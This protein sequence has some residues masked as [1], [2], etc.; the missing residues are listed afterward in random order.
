MSL[1]TPSFN[2]STSGSESS[3]RIAVMGASAVGKSAIV[4]QFVLGKFPRGYAATIQER[5]IR[6]IDVNGSHV[7]LDIFDTPGAYCFANVRRLAIANAE[8]FVLVYSVGDESSFENMAKMRDLIVQ[9]KSD[10]VPILVVGN[11]SD[12]TT[13]DRFISKDKAY[14]MVTNGWNHRYMEASAKDNENILE[15]FQLIV[16]QTK[17]YF[18]EKSRRMTS[19]TAALKRLSC[20]LRRSMT[21]N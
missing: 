7:V 1:P 10:G 8:A 2:S 9:E 16:S 13:S 14:C 19:P 17:S 5:Y 6:D 12:L 3:F 4:S 15:I 21:F 20:R 18:S 11:K